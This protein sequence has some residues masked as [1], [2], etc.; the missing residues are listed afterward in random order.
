M[1]TPCTRRTCSNPLPENPVGSFRKDSIVQGEFFC[2]V[3]CK[4]YEAEYR[5]QKIRRAEG[6]DIVQ[7]RK[8]D[9]WNKYQLTQED[10]D[11][12]YSK[13]QGLCALCLKSLDGI[14]VCVDH[15]HKTG[16]VRGLLCNDCNHGLG[17]F[18]DD[19][20]TLIRAAN[21]LAASTI[22]VDTLRGGVCP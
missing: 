19:P 9:L 1:S 8:R 6:K 11:G 17:K 5:K 14:K 7:R 20:E 10:W 15:D 4:K 13:Q 16:R 22:S 21:Y 3:T 18:R 2:S 12:M